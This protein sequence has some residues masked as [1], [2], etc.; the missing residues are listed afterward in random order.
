[1][2]TLC[3]LCS[4]LLLLSLISQHLTTWIP[5]RFPS[6]Q[7]GCFQIILPYVV[8]DFIKKQHPSICSIVQNLWMTLHNF[9]NSAQTT[10]FFLNCSSYL[11]P[12]WTLTTHYHQ[13]GPSLHLWG[14]TATSL[15][16][17]CGFM[18]PGVWLRCLFYLVLFPSASSSSN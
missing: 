2:P 8:D 5:N 16:S 17:S 9:W 15:T 12:L 7:T 14:T 1:M 13:I 4:F 10:R 6:F 3:L 11:F 18:S